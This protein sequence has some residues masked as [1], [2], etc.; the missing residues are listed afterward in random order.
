M[1]CHG[2]NCVEPSHRCAAGVCMLI[3]DFNVGWALQFPSDQ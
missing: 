3:E 2:S 1:L